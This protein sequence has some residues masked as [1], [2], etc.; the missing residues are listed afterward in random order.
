MR[1]QLLHPDRRACFV[2]SVAFVLAVGTGGV[3]VAAAAGAV[4]SIAD[5]EG[6]RGTGADEG[7]Q[8]GQ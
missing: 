3:D 5:T 1:E 4:T 6:Q 2:V 7:A 8:Q